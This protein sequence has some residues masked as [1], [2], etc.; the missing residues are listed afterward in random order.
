MTYIVGLPAHI[1]SCIMA[2]TV[3][4]DAM[5]SSPKIAEQVAEKQPAPE[6]HAGDK[7]AAD[8]VP[9]DEQ[10]PVKQSKADEVQI[11]K[12]TSSHT[13]CSA[14]LSAYQATPSML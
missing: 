11:W 7:R 4:A 8:E 9:M 1:K 13:E 6:A 10:P 2:E 14:W 5:E 3:A 12:R